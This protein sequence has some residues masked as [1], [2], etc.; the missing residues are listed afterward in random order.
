M[1]VSKLAVDFRV[2]DIYHVANSYTLN[3]PVKA[4]ALKSALE[5]KR[6]KVNV[7]VGMRYWYPF[8]EEAVHQVWFHYNFTLL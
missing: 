3:H 4:N 1:S 7:Y 6:K 8:T 5:A 2:L